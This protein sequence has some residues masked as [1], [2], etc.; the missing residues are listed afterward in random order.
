[1]NPST[2]LKIARAVNLRRGWSC[3]LGTDIR[4]ESGKYGDWNKI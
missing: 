2:G 3:A 4:A 1:M